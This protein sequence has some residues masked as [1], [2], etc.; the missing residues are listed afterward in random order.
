HG[1]KGLSGVQQFR[2]EARMAEEIRLARLGWAGC[3]RTPSVLF[4]RLMRLATGG[5][6]AP[7]TCPR[8]LSRPW[9]NLPANSC[10]VGATRVLP[11]SSNSFFEIFPDVLRIYF[12]RT[13]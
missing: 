9:T 12:M 13:G 3:R 11:A 10:V 8:D 4:R 7:V 6:T 5:I 1:R 2:G